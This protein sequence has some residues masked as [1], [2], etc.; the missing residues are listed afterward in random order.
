[1]LHERS[2]RSSAKAAPLAVGTHTDAAEE[3]ISSTECC[4]KGRKSCSPRQVAP[5][6]CHNA[7]KKTHLF[8]KKN[9]NSDPIKTPCSAPKL[10][11]VRKD[12]P[13][14]SGSKRHRLVE[15]Q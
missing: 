8:K 15:L 10:H 9:D 7:N 14:S 11:A 5:F 3:T 1:M 6:R 2:E 4:L 12:T 13:L